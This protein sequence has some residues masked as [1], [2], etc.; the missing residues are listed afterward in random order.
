MPSDYAGDVSVMEAW[1]VLSESA[2]AVLVDV[3]TR[4]E[5]SFV[6]LPDLSVIGKQVIVNE[7]QGFP[8]MAKN[9]A[10]VEE[11]AAQLASL[12]GKSPLLFLCRSGARSRAAAVAMTASGYGPC[13]NVA[14]GFEGDLDEMRHRG[15]L[16]G[17]K[18]AG[19]PWLQ[20]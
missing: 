8:S 17:W 18:V 16:N 19:L 11:L 15:S 20:S 2:D 1:R 3:R 14:G 6:G 13:Y 5:W 10:F 4:A 12:P 9:D 7:W